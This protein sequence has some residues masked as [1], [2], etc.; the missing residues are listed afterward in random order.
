MDFHRKNFRNRAGRQI[1]L[2]F[3]GKNWHNS[4]GVPVAPGTGSIMLIRRF[5]FLLLLGAVLLQTADV[6]SADLPQLTLDCTFREGNGIFLPGQSI[7]VDAAL[8]STQAESA[9]FTLRID[10]NDLSS[11][12]II[13]GFTTQMTPHVPLPIPLITPA[14]NGIYEIVLT[15]SQEVKPSR[16]LEHMLTLVPRQISVRRQFIVLSSEVAPRSAG[17]WILTETRDLLAMED[18]S[19]ARRQLLNIPRVSDLP[20]LGDLPRIAD[21][22]RP[23]NLLNIPQLGRRNSTAPSGET[24]EDVSGEPP[25]WEDKRFVILPALQGQFLEKSEKTPL[26]SALAAAKMGD[27]T[28][29]SLPI[30]ALAGE[31]YLIE[32]DYPSN[33]PQ[34]LGIAVVDFLLPWES[35]LNKLGQI[36]SAA[37]IHVAEEIVRDTAAEM[38]ATHQLLFWAKSN[39]HELVLINRQPNQEALFR[40]VRISRVTM[41]EHQEDQR[42]PKLFEGQAQRKRIGQLLGTGHL[43]DSPPNNPEFMAEYL[44]DWQGPYETSSRLIDKLHRGGYDGVTLT[45]L[46]KDVSL[47]PTTSPTLN[48]LEMLF[49]RFSRE[50]L[51]LIPAIEFDLPI[52]SLERLLH[53]HPGITEEILIGNPRDRQYNLLHPAVQQAMGEI[54]LDLVNRFGHHPSFGGVAVLLAPET[55]AQL[56]FAVYPP[57]DYTFAQFRQETEQQLGVPFPDEQR[58]RTTMPTQQFLVQK[59]AERLQ[60]LQSDRKIWDTWIRWRAAKVSGFYANLA[61]QIASRRSDAPLYLLGG[62]MLDQ[63]EIHDYCMPTLPR[64]FAPLQAIQLLGFDL[65][66][67]AQSESLHFLK[68]VRMDVERNYSYDDLNSADTISRF[69]TSGA[70]PGVQ[71]VHGSGGTLAETPTPVHAQS[72]KRF[73]RQ[74]AQADVMMFMDGGASLPF[75]QEPAMFDLLDTYRRLPPVPLLTFQTAGTSPAHEHSSVQPLTVRYRNLPEGMVMYIVNDAP[76]SVEADFFFSADLSSRMTELT[77]HRM[78]RTFS[79]SPQRGTHTWRASLLPYDL[80]AVRISDATARIESVSVHRPASLYGAEGALKQKAEELNQRAH[81]ARSGILWEGL[82]NPDFE[83]PLDA[84]GGIVGWQC[85]GQS[86]TAVLD[87]TAQHKGEQSVKLTNSGAESGTFLSQ[88]LDI[89][90]TGRLGI[91]MFV[92]I[93]EGSLSLPMNV[94]LTAKHRGQPYFRSASAEESVISSLAN[95]VPKN[96]VRWH[97]LVVSFGRLPTDSL[98]DVRIGVQ[99]SGNGAVWLDDITLYQ[100]LFSALEMTE[101]QKMSAVAYQRHTSERV[102]DLILQLEGHWPQFLFDYVPAPVPQPRVSTASPPMAKEVPP[103]KPPTLYQRVRGVFGM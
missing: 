97:P 56:P 23:A 45:V 11:R 77:G 6:R 66:L 8:R 72:R 80:L 25:W 18:D 54:V 50:G 101:L 52:P 15:A 82:L 37:T 17:S 75:G 4:A 24:H 27:C 9:P 33:I 26:F 69:T 58:L 84:A 103:P 38:T 99:Y 100:A 90:A 3:F 44:N 73:V 98:E 30:E 32:I 46:S 39:T 78:I 34:T 20:R 19:P 87:Q 14:K 83:L 5:V 13:G 68:P 63:P 51:T 42:L 88:P 35:Q 12:S 86:L 81:A 96:G 93:P 22:P 1:A 10:V 59:N 79:R 91:S 47:Y 40:N 74:L 7:I 29:L 31:P 60:F 55:Y 95:T 28:W 92:G 62:T 49:Q 61:R 57:D 2:V 53:E 36:N 94:V 67:I 65:P 89:P 16:P 43:V 102:S 21:L 76:F 41:P 64:N 70:L 48:Y 85:F 71:F